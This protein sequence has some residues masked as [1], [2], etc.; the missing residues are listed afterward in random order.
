MENF[1]WIH[2]SDLH[3]SAESDFDTVDAREKLIKKL[4]ELTATRNGRLCDYIFIT[5]DIANKCDYKNTR[6][7]MNRLLKALGI[8]SKKEIKERVFWAVGNHDI[9][10]PD[11]S[12]P[13]DTVINE[14]RESGDNSLEFKQAMK[15]KQRRM[16]LTE[17]GMSQ[18]IDNYNSLFGK[19]IKGEH[20]F[21]D[22]PQ[23]NLI[24]LNTCLT[25][26]D[27][28][29]ERN[30][31]VITDDTYKQFQE[32]IKDGKP[33]I[34]LGHHDISYLYKE[35]ATNLNKLFGSYVDFYLCGHS[36]QL[37]YQKLGKGKTHQFT[38]GGGSI[39]NTN[40]FSFMIGEYN[41]GT[42]KVKITPYSYR[43]S[44]NCEWSVDFNLD[45][46]IKNRS[47]FPVMHVKQEKKPTLPK[48]TKVDLMGRDKELEE[49][50]Q[51][52]EEY[53]KA[54]ISANM[55]YGKTTLARLYANKHYNKDNYVEVVCD[56]IQNIVN[57]LN[58]DIKKI[59]A[60]PL[61]DSIYHKLKDI[62]KKYELII[63]DNLCDESEG[64]TDYKGSAF[65]LIEEVLERF[66]DSD[67]CNVIITTRKS[68]NDLYIFNS[69]CYYELNELDEKYAIAFLNDNNSDDKNEGFQRLLKKFGTIPI[70]LK[71]IKAIIKAGSDINDIENITLGYEPK[72]D[73]SDESLAHL[74]PKLFE[75]L[76]SSS[77]EFIYVYI[78]KI[79]SII[80]GTGITEDFL[81]KVITTEHPFLMRDQFGKLRPM[82]DKY[83]VIEYEN[84]NCYKI[85]RGYQAAIRP[86]ISLKEDM[87]IVEGVISVIR[88]ELNLF[89]YY[90][91]DE[92]HKMSSY[93]NHIDALK[94]NYRDNIT[95]LE[96]ICDLLT[97][98]AWYDGYVLGAK[99]EPLRERYE[100]IKKL[101][102]VKWLIKGLCS[103]DQMLH[104][105]YSIKKDFDKSDSQ[106]F[107]TFYDNV[108][109]DIDESL[110]Q[111]E[112]NKKD[113]MILEIRSSLVRIDFCNYFGHKEK[114]IRL[115]KDVLANFPGF[116][117]G[118]SDELSVFLREH[119]VMILNR[120]G[121]FQREM[122]NYEDA[123][124]HHNE[125]L[126][127]LNKKDTNNDIAIAFTNNLIRVCDY[128]RHN[129]YEKQLAA[130]SEFIETYKTY[131]EANYKYGMCNQIENCGMSC[132]KIAIDINR[133]QNFIEENNKIKE[134]KQRLKGNLI[135]IDNA[136][137]N[138]NI[139]ARL[140]NASD[141]SGLFD[142]IINL[143]EKC[144]DWSYSKKG[145]ALTDEFRQKINRYKY[146][147]EWTKSNKNNITPNEKMLCYKKARSYLTEAIEA[148]KSLNLKFEE[149]KLHRYKGML[150]RNINYEQG[151]PDYI[152]CIREFETAIA[153]CGNN[154]EDNYKDYQLA[155]I[156]L[157]VAYCNDNDFENLNNLVKNICTDLIQKIKKDKMNESE[158]ITTHFFWKLNQIETKYP[159]EKRPE[160]F[161]EL[162]NSIK[163]IKKKEMMDFIADSF[164]DGQVHCE[165][166]LSDEEVEIITELYS[167]STF[168]SISEKESGKM[169][170][171]VNLGVD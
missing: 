32:N 129:D 96:N 117:A 152:E 41:A 154:G 2:F 42:N 86:L 46:E 113:K 20:A 83:S 60:M 104:N 97:H 58:I 165:L 151:K 29:D 122:A 149:S 68:M 156:E 77:D 146:E 15:S 56:T 164:K 158:T 111:L 112:D 126:S 133:N 12:E 115:A 7:F 93:F 84:E 87:W 35:D 95:V 100:T 78:L 45:G 33:T 153:L 36:H 98:S 132:R 25:S 135:D 155:R 114:A 23:F 22:Y 61:A 44:G 64:N 31:H 169:W 94:E 28:N 73:G 167:F 63:L 52:L 110:R 142:I 123:L 51:K 40:T 145:D 159:S 161:V 49:I 79:A 69:D 170:F 48:K 76:K 1:R 3:L 90:G 11:S 17:F 74:L 6:E 134:L 128:E 75:K 16:L 125:A 92:W 10:R 157:C 47:S 21:Y 72:N 143:A 24:V 26:H 8:T 88:N 99:E 30:L 55:G 171:D 121:M 136:V 34:A 138:N 57:G 120:L 5:G 116:I 162:E 71:A 9:E 139:S 163:N 91:F 103:C 109:L 160:E 102:N 89:S 53:K 59:E 39:D 105:L 4:T 130:I 18:Y 124:F 168:D 50:S 106:D 82:A 43:H 131:K 67:L 27:N 166:R 66:T 141:I 62:S 37:G 54:V 107:K 80:S 119:K 147:V 85:H 13:R 144:F 65:E 140:Y 148:N 150:L 81:K 14:I 137:G 19:S 38:C 108:F 70:V 118:N 101:V 127:L